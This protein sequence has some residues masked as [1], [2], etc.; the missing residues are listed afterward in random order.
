MAACV[1]L[2][3]LFILAAFVQ[4]QDGFI[5]IDCGRQERT[6]YTDEQTG[7]FYTS[8]A[9]YIKTGENRQIPTTLFPTLLGRQFRNIRRFPEGTRN[10]YTLK[11]LV[12][13]ERYLIRASFMHGDYENEH[14][15]FDVYLGVNLWVSISVVNASAAGWSEIITVATSDFVPV[16]LVKKKG[17]PFVSVL[18][19]RR[20]GSG[21]YNVTDE[22]Q[23]L[24]LYNR[25]DVGSTPGK[26]LRYKDD[27]YDR[28]W[29]TLDPVNDIVGIRTISATSPTANIEDGDTFQVPP[30]VLRTAATALNRTTAA[31]MMVNWTS[32]D[33]RTQYHFFRHFAEVEQ[34]KEGELREF[35]VCILGIGCQGPYRP[36]YLV[37]STVF[38]ATPV[39]G[40]TLY[41]TY[42]E[43]TEASTLPP[44][45]NAVELYSLVNL[46]VVP[47]AEQDLEA[48]LW[49]R[50]GYNVIKN[51]MGDPCVPRI[52]KWEG[53]DCSYHESVPPSIVSLN[54]AAAGL[55]GAIATSIGNLSSL[56]S[57]DLSRNNLTGEIPDFLA[58][59]HF[60]TFLNLAGNNFTGLVPSKLLQMSKAGT[61]QLSID[62]NP[63]LSTDPCSDN[64]CKK[65]KSV[66]VPIAVSLSVVALLVLVSIF[67]FWRK[68][69]QRIRKPQAAPVVKSSDPL[70]VLDSQRFSY[71]D[72]INITSDLKR[73]LGKGGFGV[74]YHGKM[75]DGNEVA[76]KMLSRECQGSSEF[77]T[78][79][80]LLMK[81]FHRN[82]VHLI[83]YCSEGDKKALI[84][85]YMSKGNLGDLL[86]DNSRAILTWEQRIQIA[87]DIARG[88]E[89]LHV[90]CRPPI[91]HRDV[92]AANI[93]LNERLEA[94]IADFG[95]SK[96]FYK[97]HEEE[98][99]HITT[100]VKGTF[101]YLDPEYFFSHTLNEKS[102]VYSYGVVLLELITGKSAIVPTSSS[103]SFRISLVEW[104]SPFV[105]KGNIKNVIDGRLR[106]NYDSNSAWKALDIA[107]SCTR[108]KGVDRPTMSAVVTQCGSR[109]R[110]VVP[111]FQV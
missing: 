6:N 36:T 24:V 107:V 51:W 80:Q 41:T 72:I 26:R 45:L 67:I 37:G 30:A 87:S 102:D 73:V 78:E 71:A 62:N 54:L 90:G 42:F 31:S 11:P 61:L 44:L 27:I 7:I 4:A 55:T 68:Y 50:D 13:G 25:Y 3:F 82:L 43:M 15:S 63:N 70:L 105:S 48:M 20:L 69:S 77:Q 84:L 95:L 98:F 99:T 96:V 110:F 100:A 108:P 104:V 1:R 21:M 101:G 64:S 19:L 32:D 12:K 5:S 93:L 39:S 9:D 56:Q 49:I 29:S 33:P 91:I 35:N 34:L 10:C 97:D 17:T 92:K 58:T 23:A 103:D 83:G 22:S 85:D 79:A 106:G 94:K 88:L 8:D 111:L 60:L 47:T 52:Y 109:I 65:K 89:Y 38:T 2:S 16:C 40:R 57:L 81:V 59:L 14:P 66:A 75:A 28:I 53:L 86:K 76:V 18:E 74:V 46:S